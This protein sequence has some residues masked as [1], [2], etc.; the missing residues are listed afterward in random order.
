MGNIFIA[1][2]ESFPFRN[3]CPFRKVNFKPV[4]KGFKVELINCVKFVKI[5]DLLGAVPFFTGDIGFSTGS[6]ITGRGGGRQKD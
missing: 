4:E 2:I 1:P 6:D 5:P 3:L